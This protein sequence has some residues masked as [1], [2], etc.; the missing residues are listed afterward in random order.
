MDRPPK[1]DGPSAP[2]PELEPP[3]VRTPSP[4]FALK[5]LERRA[6]VSAFPPHAP[7]APTIS[8]ASGPRFEV[9]EEADQARTAV[10]SAS[11]SGARSL[12]H[13]APAPEPPDPGSVLG[14][15]SLTRLRAIGRF[16]RYELL[17]RIAYGGMA[18]I[19]LARE[20]CE[21][22]ARA[23]RYVVIKRV[24][25]HIAEDPQF[26]DMFLD[27]ARLAMRLSHPNICHVYAF[28]EEQGSFYLAMEW[29]NGMPLSK[30]HR[31]ARERRCG[32]PIPIALR[33]IAQVAEALD[34]AHRVCDENGNPLGI[35]H[36]DVSPQNVMIAFDGPVKLLDFGIAKAVS[37]DTR[38]EAGIV[39]GKFAYMSPQQCLGE[40]IDARAD[41]FALGLCLYEI[42]VGRNPFKRQSEFDTMRAIV[43]EELPP[44]ADVVAEREPRP[45]IVTAIEAVITRALAK[46]CE[47]RFQSAADM[48][49]AL[50][51]VLGRMGEVVTAARIGEFMHELFDAEIKA[52]PALDTRGHLPPPGSSHA[53]MTDEQPDVAPPI[54]VNPTEKVPGAPAMPG[55]ESASRSDRSRSP[56]PLRGVL[57]GAALFLLGVTGAVAAWLAYTIGTLQAHTEV[58]VPATPAPAPRLP[59]ATGGSLYVDSTPPGARIELGSGGVVGTTPMEIAMLEPG[60]VQVRLTADGYEPWERA[61]EIRAGE[62]AHLVAQLAAVRSAPE[63]P[64]SG[65]AG[66]RERRERERHEST[67]TGTSPNLST[68]ASASES[69]ARDEGT[70]PRRGA[71]TGYISVNSRPWSKVYVGSRLLGTTPIGS[72]EVESGTVRLRLVDRDGVEHIRTITVPTGGHAREF[73]DLRAATE[74]DAP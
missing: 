11:N 38:T 37:R 35:V 20:I 7:A 24:L 23:D 68:A 13:P 55:A 62:R 22:G 52:G 60:R 49:I 29:V 18:E 34:H 61:L 41:V 71:P 33:V 42:I 10:R 32:I 51:Q 9:A 67:R 70:G 63:R 59:P 40:P 47:D 25:P 44:I 15:A 28:G 46:R 65:E 2:P 56:S 74:G 45:E 66:S 50:E 30:V 43:Y 6:V 69:A 19:F 36:R 57:L 54:S 21:A 17:G 39:K 8:D 53:G 72:V 58:T 26:I 73:F 14:R 12:A 31:R 3:P 64:R 27:E 16:G 1:P 4:Q 5:H 48:Q